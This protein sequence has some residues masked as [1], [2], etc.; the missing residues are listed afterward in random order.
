MI[1]VAGDTRAGSGRDLMHLLAIGYPDPVTGLEAMELLKGSDRDLIIRWDEMAAVVRDEHGSFTT[2]T[3]AVITS[4]RPSWAMFWW[5]LFAALFYVPMLRM[6]VGPGLESSLAD[7]TGS[8][9]DPLFEE[10]IRK[11][12]TPDTSALFVLIERVTPDRVVSA[13]D[14]FGGSVFGNRISPDLESHLEVTLNG[15]P[16]V[17]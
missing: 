9:L 4:G 11:E 14:R 16:R 1:D 8:G 17:A 10:K 12:L 5:H 2:Y 3:N 7:V 15:P 6:P 13:L